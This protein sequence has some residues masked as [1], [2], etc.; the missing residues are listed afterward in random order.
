MALFR[1]TKVELFRGPKVALFRGPKV[2]LFRG[3]KVVFFCG[4]QKWI[5]FG[6]PEVNFFR[7]P[8]V[9]LFVAAQCRQLHSSWVEGSSGWRR[10]A[11]AICV[12]SGHIR[13]IVTLSCRKPNVLDVLDGN[14]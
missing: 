14:I 13:H 7:G 4:A 12:Q 5:F 8:E 6:D 2:E 11:Q 10:A 3:P 1:G 9:E